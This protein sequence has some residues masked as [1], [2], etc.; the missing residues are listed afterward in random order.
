MIVLVVGDVLTL[1]IHAGVNMCTGSGPID[2]GDVSGEP[3]VAPGVDGWL[4][5]SV[6]GRPG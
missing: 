1:T 3:S 6:E 2:D 4:V 5:R